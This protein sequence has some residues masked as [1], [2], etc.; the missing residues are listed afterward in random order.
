MRHALAASSIILA[1]SASHV[2]AVPITYTETTIASGS[3]GGSAFT[4]SQVTVS[5]V[6]DTDSVVSPM[7]GFVLNAVGTASVSVAGGAAATFDAGRQTAFVFQGMNGAGIGAQSRDAT[8]DQGGQTYILANNGPA[9]S[10]Y[11]LRSAIGPVVGPAVFRPGLAFSTTAG[12]FTLTSASA[13]TYAAAAAP[14]AVPE[15]DSLVL[16]GA[17]L[18]GFI[19]A[20]VSKLRPVNVRAPGAGH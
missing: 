7:P 5:F 9:F 8:V 10:A 19:L 1:L 20:G 4:D 12:D 11:D 14:T 17:G 13:V 3:L 15:P 16:L 2:Q 6:G 18:L